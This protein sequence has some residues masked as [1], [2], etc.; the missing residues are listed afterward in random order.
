MKEDDDGCTPSTTP[1]VVALNELVDCRFS[2]AGAT[3][4]VYELKTCED[5]RALSPPSRLS[6]SL[7]DLSL[8]RWRKAAAR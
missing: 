2:F 6:L 8:H 4:G 3:C 1:L 7:S 5:C